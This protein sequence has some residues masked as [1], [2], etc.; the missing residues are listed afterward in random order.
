MILDGQDYDLEGDSKLQPG[1]GSSTIEGGTIAT[2][3]T[4]SA[5]TESSKVIEKGLHYGPLTISPDSYE[6]NH[7][8]ADAILK[9]GVHPYD[10]APE[11][12]VKTKT[13]WQP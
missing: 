13:I 12:I 9:L 7:L 8:I 10:E 2:E 4:V 1:S 6:I 11:I 3:I 5:K